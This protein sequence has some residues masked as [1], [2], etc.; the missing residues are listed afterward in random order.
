MDDDCEVSTFP[1]E[2]CVIHQ[3][4]RRWTGIFRVER[5]MRLTDWTTIG[6]PTEICMYTVRTEKGSFFINCLGRH[7]L[8]HITHIH[9]PSRGATLDLPNGSP[10]R[11]TR[12]FSGWRLVA[13]T[14]TLPFIG[15]HVIPDR[16]ASQA[17]VASLSWRLVLPSKGRIR[18]PCVR[19]LVV[20]ILS[21]KYHSS[22]EIDC[23]CGDFVDDSRIGSCGSTNVDR[24]RG[25][26]LP[27]SDSTLQWKCGPNRFQLGRRGRF[28]MHLN[29]Y[30]TIYTCDS[31][32]T[33]IPS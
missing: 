23:D 32:S 11:A 31:S 10:P 21:T 24:N 27:R 22:M 2:C 15:P 30:H 18:N 9:G 1:W 16:S 29:M 4:G 19:Y 3:Q 12:C 28:D 13:W 17:S 25:K 33:S 5:T 26:Q 14:F 6:D 8:S 7:R 20:A